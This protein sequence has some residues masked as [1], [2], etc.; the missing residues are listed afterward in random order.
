MTELSGLSDFEGRVNNNIQPKMAG[1]RFRSR[2]ILDSAGISLPPKLFVRRPNKMAYTLILE[3]PRSALDVLPYGSENYIQ[4]D[5]HITFINPMNS[6]HKRN[7]LI[8]PFLTRYSFH[9]SRMVLICK[10]FF[11]SLK[12]VFSSKGSFL[13]FLFLQGVMTSFYYP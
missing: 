5:Q 7:I 13:V 4:R 3:A 8:I 6:I 11:F 12:L 9:V 1:S 10:S 2:K